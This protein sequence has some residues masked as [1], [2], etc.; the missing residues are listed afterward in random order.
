M[1]STYKNDKGETITKLLLD[2]QLKIAGL[3]NDAPAQE[4]AQSLNLTA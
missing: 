2:A 3:T 1:V 4:E